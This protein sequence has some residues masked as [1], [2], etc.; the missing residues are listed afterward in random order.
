[1]DNTW[2]KTDNSLL[3]SIF[4]SG[5]NSK[6]LNIIVGSPDYINMAGV[7]KSNFSKYYTRII[8]DQILKN[9]RKRKLYEFIQE[10]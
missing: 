5:L 1:M 3:D 10:H 6:E 4:S 9:S 2:I 7:G 8:K